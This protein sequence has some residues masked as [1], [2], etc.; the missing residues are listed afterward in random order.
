MLPHDLFLLQMPK[1]ATYL[2]L[3]I[4]SALGPFFFTLAFYILFPTIVVSLVYEKEVLH[5]RLIKP[6]FNYKIHFVRV[7]FYLN[8]SCWITSCRL[9]V[10]ISWKLIFRAICVEAAW[11]RRSKRYLTNVSS[12]RWNCE[13]WCEWWASGRLLIGS[14]TTS[15]GLFKSH[16]FDWNMWLFC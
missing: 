2:S 3:D 6:D 12:P 8:V 4:G 11:R 10:W 16:H 5:S 14:L 7:F 13:L 15:F 1:I 9:I